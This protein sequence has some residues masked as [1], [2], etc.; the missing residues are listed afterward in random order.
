M[1]TFGSTALTTPAETEPVRRAAR[2]RVPALRG[3]RRH[4]GGAARDARG[5]RGHPALHHRRRLDRPRARRS[6]TSTPPPR[7]CATGRS[8]CTRSWPAA[9]SRP[10][11]SPSTSR[12]G[13]A[14]RPRLPDGHARADRPRLLGAA[15]HQ[16]RRGRARLQRLTD[17]KEN[18]H[19]MKAITLDELGTQPALR[20]D[21]PAPTPGPDEV[22][23]RV[24]ASSVNPV[25][26]AI[27]AGMLKDMVEHEF[28]ITLGRD[29]AGVVEQVGAD[30]TALLRRRRGVRLPPRDDPDRAR[31]QLGR[32]HRRP[33]EHVDR[34]QARRRGPRHRRRRRRWPAITAMTRHRRARAR[35]GRH[36]CSSSARP[37]ASAASPSSSP[38]PPARP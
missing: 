29:Y 8:T 19:P 23:V 25:D 10:P 16:P 37:A 3:H 4:Q 35:R 30:V 9:A 33:R 26:N 11:T 36:A 12:L 15:H 34:P 2:D 7:R 24:R 18:Q 28:P 31:R 1:G 5:R 21:L 20:T 32:A 27:A 6:A 38:P 17:S 13:D 14:R 22:L